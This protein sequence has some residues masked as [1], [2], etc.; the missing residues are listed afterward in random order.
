MKRWLPVLLA[1]V[2]FL[3][4]VACDSN[5]DSNRENPTL[6]RCR[7]NS[8]C[9]TALGQECIDGY[10]A[11]PDINPGECK[12]H[13]DCE[14]GQLCNET[15]HKCESIG[16]DEE[17]PSC[18]ENL[19]CDGTQD[20]LDKGYRNYVCVSLCCI[21]PGVTDGDKEYEIA[22]G[23][24]SCVHTGCPNGFECNRLSGEC[25]VS[26][27]SCATS[28]CPTNYECDTEKDECVP[29]QTH[30][31]N[32]SCDPR[33]ECDQAS[34]NC[35][36]KPT[37]CT[38][39]PCQTNYE[40]NQ[41]T[42]L[43]DPSANHCAVKG[44]PEKYGC[45]ELTGSCNPTPDHCS[46]TPCGDLFN[47]NPTSGMCEP[48]S[49]NCTVS[50]C[51][52]KYDCNAG[53]GICSPS[54]EHCLTTPC[55]GK[56]R[57]DEQLGDCVPNDEHC[58][59]TNCQTKYLCEEASGDCKPGPNHC[60]TKPCAEHF[61]CVT[62]SG[63]CVPGPDHCSTTSCNVHYYCDFESGGCKPA[64]DH[65]TITPCTGGF[66]CK[67]D[68]GVCWPPASSCTGSCST[69]K[70]STCINANFLCECDEDSETKGLVDC[71]QNCYDRGY[72][73]LDQCE[74]YTD[75]SSSTKYYKCVCD[76]YDDGQGHCSNPIAINKFPFYHSWSVPFLLPTNEL[77]F[78][79]CTQIKNRPQKDGF[80]RIYSFAA[81]AGDVFEFQMDSLIGDGY[82]TIRDSC[83][84]SFTYCDMIQGTG[85]GSFG[86]GETYTFN[87][88]QSGT[89]YLSIEIPSNLGAYDLNVTRQ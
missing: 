28:G 87:V 62:E 5:S 45:E 66:I 37:D 8:E 58:L 82:I 53:T 22:D 40:C 78:N 83:S 27:S 54:A 16:G 49:T 67:E 63:D 86:L 39:Q 41:T 80:E 32:A 3:M 47:C 29:S 17:K 23:E 38:L 59:V 18:D 46:N 52:T 9:E 85:Y 14:A 31:V 19:Q 65:C 88:T 70:D 60:S 15:T 44:C 21:D 13:N 89:Y 84:N 51:P 25:E 12:S 26:S 48:S 35:N 81:N 55:T 50:G 57:C 6:K 42:G 7:Q 76:N 2:L 72:P 56:Y 69:V 79:R 74:L 43:C 61:R 33:Y 34:G 64:S 11:I 24:Q 4:S 77:S 1:F 20:C 36:L 10:C 68:T 73:Y 71:L 30:C 75:S